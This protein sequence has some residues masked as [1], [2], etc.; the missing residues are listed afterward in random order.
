MLKRQKKN[1]YKKKK[2]ILYY[3]SFNDEY[4]NIIKTLS[5]YSIVMNSL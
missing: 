2:I 1:I 4:S 5:L 3:S